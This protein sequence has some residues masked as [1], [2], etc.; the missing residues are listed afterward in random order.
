[1]AFCRRDLFLV[2]VDCRQAQPGHMYRAF[3]ELASLATVAGAEEGTVY[4]VRAPLLELTKA[5]II[6]RGLE[7]GVDYRLTWSCYDPTPAG[8]AC[9]RCDSCQLRRKGFADAGAEDP[10]AYDL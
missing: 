4:R 5:E 9:G 1:M 2:P 3:E 7:L 8:L 6:A 10:V